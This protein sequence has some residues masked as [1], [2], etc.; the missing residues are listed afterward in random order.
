[1]VLFNLRSIRMA[2]VAQVPSLPH[3]LA[4]KLEQKNSKH[5]HLWYNRCVIFTSYW[6]YEFF[7]PRFQVAHHDDSSNS[8]ILHRYV[9]TVIIDGTHF[10]LLSHHPGGIL[11]DFE[12][13]FG[14]FLLL[15]LL[16]LFVLLF[17][18]SGSARLLRIIS[19]LLVILL[20]FFVGWFLVILI[21]ILEN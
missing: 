14:L 20:F 2:L 5:C 3:P 6:L 21:I 4:R 11:E 7:L 18:G 13:R 9:L 19:R 12:T 16:I 10:Q 8:N 1:M 17:L 15:L